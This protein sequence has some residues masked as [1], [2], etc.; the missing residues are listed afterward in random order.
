M[1][2]SGLARRLDQFLVREEVMDMGHNIRKWVGTGGLLDHLP[3]YMEIGRGRDK[4]KGPFKFSSI[5]LKD[6][7]YI[8]MVTEFWK[9]N[10][11]GVGG[12][13]STGF[14]S[15]LKD[16]KKLSQNWAL[17]KRLQDDHSLEHIENELEVFEK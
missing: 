14:I 17:H 13:T 15:S 9:S 1:G 10:P 3:I 6:A 11:P 8:S 7:S 4:P 2:E 5:W 12:I 16:L